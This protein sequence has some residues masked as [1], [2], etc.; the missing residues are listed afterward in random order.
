LDLQG[1][2]EIIVVD[3]G[4]KD[5]TLEK[6]KRFDSVKVF[7]SDKGRAHQMNFGAQ[8]ANGDL[9]VF[10]HADTFLPK[11]F[12]KDILNLMQ[13][14]KVVGGSFRLRMDDRHFIFKFYNWCSQFSLEFFTY[15]DHAMFMKA[16]SFRRIVGFK[17][18]PFMEDV[19]IQKRIR[20]EGKFKKL[21]SS[22]TTS[23]RRFQKNG[24]IYQLLVDAIL[25]LLFKLGVSAKRLKRFYPDH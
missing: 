2:F 4:S 3:G 6:V 19:E 12:Y 9:L 16:E 21:S 14:T 10:L 5:S 15:G 22:V 11:T 18:T 20:N 7:Q 8:H 23:N 1:Y 17:T 13:N 25:V 24:V